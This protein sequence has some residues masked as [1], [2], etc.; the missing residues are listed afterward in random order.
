MPRTSPVAPI[1][2]SPRSTPAPVP[3]LG[4]TLF[5]TGSLPR[6]LPAMP[7]SAPPTLQ[8]TRSTAGT[9]ICRPMRA[10]FT[11]HMCSWSC[12]AWSTSSLFQISTLRLVPSTSCSI[13]PMRLLISPASR[14]CIATH[15]ARPPV[16][17]RN[18]F[19]VRADIALP[20]R[21]SFLSRISINLLAGITIVVPVMADAGRSEEKRSTAE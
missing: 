10:F 16:T 6:V 14:D 3:I 4:S 5:P 11:F 21:W 2:E 17:E 1:T 7:P 15:R 19:F 9:M 12:I 13:S 18:T 20:S 8:E